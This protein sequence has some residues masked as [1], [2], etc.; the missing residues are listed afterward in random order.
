M[1]A[2]LAP[3][4]LLSTE[5]QARL[6]QEQMGREALERQRRLADIAARR[7]SCEPVKIKRRWDGGDKPTTRTVHERACAKFR[8]WMAEV[9]PA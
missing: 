2:K 3:G 5:D 8:S 6:Y 9:R 7:C 4:S 1:K